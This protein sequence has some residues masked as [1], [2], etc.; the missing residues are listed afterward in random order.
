MTYSTASTKRTY[1]QPPPLTSADMNMLT[2]M[3]CAECR[4]YGDP[5]NATGLAMAI[6]RF[7]WGRNSWEFYLKHAGRLCS[8]W[9]ANED[10]MIRA[11]YRTH[12][13]RDLAAVAG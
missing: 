4:R 5:V 11:A 2:K 6:Y 1:R 3:F 13:E 10:R 9:L 12:K 7:D 8:V